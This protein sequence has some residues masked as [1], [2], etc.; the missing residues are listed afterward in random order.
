MTA[1]VVVEF[2]PRLCVE[3]I[4][5]KNHFVDCGLDGEK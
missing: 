2:I 4:L 3:D 1:H 5:G